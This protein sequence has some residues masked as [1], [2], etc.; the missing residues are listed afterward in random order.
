MNDTSAGISAESAGPEGERAR[1]Y[2]R[3]RL[4]RFDGPTRLGRGVPVTSQRPRSYRQLPLGA[5]PGDSRAGASA[6]RGD[7][8][9]RCHVALAALALCLHRFSGRTWI[10]MGART[11][12]AAWPGQAVPLL[13]SVS[14]AETFAGLVTRV[15]DELRRATEA[16]PGAL[17]AGMT[18]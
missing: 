9:G 14:A 17:A 12:A 13:I 11:A 8:A 7:R 10:S 2:W 18:E 15:T 1:Q 16:G 4:M 3:D 6:G 5:S